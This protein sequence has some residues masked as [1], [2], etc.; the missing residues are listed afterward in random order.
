MGL[1]II[2][3]VSVWVIYAYGGRTLSTV[4]PQITNVATSNSTVVPF[5]SAEEFKNYLVTATA[6]SDGPRFITQNA[7]STGLAKNNEMMFGAS[8]SIVDRASSTNVQVVGV[9]EPD[10]VKNDGASI[11]LSNNL[12]YSGDVMQKR[13][14][15]TVNKAVTTVI[16]ALPPEK[17]SQASA[18]IDAGDL[19]LYK[20]T[21]II[22]SEQAIIG[23]NISN[24][25]SPTQAW[26]IKLSDQTIY[27]TARLYQ[28]TLYVVT[29]TVVNSAQ[30]CPFTPLTLDTTG[31]ILECNTIY[32]PTVSTAADSIF[33]VVGVD[34][35]TGTTNQKISFV[36]SPSNV[37]LYM[38]AKNLYLTYAM[39]T[40]IMTMMI[41]FLN[42]SGKGIV[43]D[44]VA[45][46]LQQVNGYDISAEAKMMEFG[47]IVEKYQASLSKDD[48]LKLENEL[49]NRMKEYVGQHKRTLTSTMITQLALDTF[50]VTATGAVPG[51]LLN[52]FS[53]DEY[54]GNLRVATT[55]G[56]GRGGMMGNI[57][58]SDQQTN[59]LYVLDA[60]LHT[61][62]QVQDLGNG[63][64]VYSA[65]FVGK[66]GYVVTFKQTDPFFVFDLSN[67]TAPKK[68][69]ELKIPGYSS[70]LHPLSETM[71]VGIGKEGSNVKLSLFNVTDPANPTEQAHYDLQEYS[72]DLL[73]TH[74]AFLQDEKHKVLFIPGSKGGYVFSYD[75]NTLTLK[76]AV[77]DVYAQRALYINDYLYIIGRNGI[78]VLSETDWSEVGKL[79]LQNS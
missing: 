48:R 33:T 58:S 47:Q 72:S 74:H 61:I 45:A 41:D 30:S 5:N 56:G 78:T 67:P 9:D 64:R 19:L 4:L 21:L 10:M 51:T 2:L 65:R 12:D 22:F 39:S 69:G 11:F 37:V 42:T 24:P 76:K 25:T 35:T 29:R 3:G 38:S 14:M 43:S 57:V 7:I 46:H 1:S 16:T 36:G 23:Y 55:I 17:I 44:D 34:P 32:H 63:E 60:T 79:E 62:G 75:N 8:D 53:M 73:E 18:I 50:V 13:I 15:P 40:D 68:T 66:Q 27:Q 31:V 49:E 28:D 26:E 59:D 54:Q 6:V 71:I 20:D 52:Q 70:Y 77:S